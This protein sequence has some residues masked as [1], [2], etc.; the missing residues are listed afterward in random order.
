MTVGQPGEIELIVSDD[1]SISAEQLRQLGLQP[2]AHLRVF[3]A[4]ASS[5]PRSLVGS[6]PDFPDLDWEDFEAGS[7]LARQD[8][9]SACP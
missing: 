9:A 2:G 3:E 7:E 4:S 1:G 5:S 8:A 6:L